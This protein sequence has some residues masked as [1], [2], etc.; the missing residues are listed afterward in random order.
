MILREEVKGGLWSRDE[1]ERKRSLLTE[2]ALCVI[3]KKKSE[4]ERERPGNRQTTSSDPID[5]TRLD[6]LFDH[7]DSVV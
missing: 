1:R 6:S 4:R 2:H 3:K 7:Q 5:S